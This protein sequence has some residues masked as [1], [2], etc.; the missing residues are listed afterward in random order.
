MLLSFIIPVYNATPY[1]RKCIESIFTLG[2]PENEMEIVC[3]NDC[4]TDNTAD[5]IKT[6]SKEHPSVVLIN[7]TENKRQGGGSNTAIRAICGEY[8]VFMDQDDTI[9][10]YDLLG[11]IKYM[12]ENQLDLLL[13]RVVCLRQDGS[14]HYWSDYP[15]QTSIIKGPQLFNDGLINKVG[16]GAVWMGIY[17]TSLLK[18]TTSFVEN[19]IYE[20]TDWC[21]QCAYNASRVQYKPID[22]YLYNDNPYSSTHNVPEIWLEWRVR[23][24]LRVYYWANG[25]SIIEGREDVL[26]SSEE[27]YTWNLLGLRSIWK[28]NNKDRR[29][30]FNAFTYE[31]YSIFKKWPRNYWIMVVL[32]YPKLSEILLFFAAPCARLVKKV[33]DFI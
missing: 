9:L 1:I 14:T 21:F 16:F 19:M 25:P 24:S 27:F 26:A 29:H 32:Q 22:I 10:P 11:E 7:H 12:R 31:E 20:D 33:K 30:F 17:K 5:V 2:I 8:A 28:Y 4:S 13:G 23:A 15:N 3:V 6:I 18:R